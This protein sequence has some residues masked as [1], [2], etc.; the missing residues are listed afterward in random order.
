MIA[1][2]TPPNANPTPLRRR[3]PY[4][5]ISMLCIPLIC[6]AFSWVGVRASGAYFT[7]R[8]MRKA[9]DA[10]ERN[11]LE[12]KQ[13]NLRMENE[14]KSMKTNAGIIRAARR[15]GWVQQGEVHLKVP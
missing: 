15:L 5:F 1:I 9:N 6:L 2:A 13:K 14:V 10:I 7:A 3:S 12:M 8:D 11:Y 4:R